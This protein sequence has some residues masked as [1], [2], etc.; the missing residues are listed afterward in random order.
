[1]DSDQSAGD[2]QRQ[3]FAKQGG[4]ALDLDNDGFNDSEDV[5]EEEDDPQEIMKAQQ[6]NKKNEADKPAG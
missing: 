5:D 1:M 3:Q 4:E 6:N 2:E